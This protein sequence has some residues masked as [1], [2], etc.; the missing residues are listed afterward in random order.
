MVPKP[1]NSW[2]ERRYVPGSPRL[3]LNPVFNASSMGVPSITRRSYRA[4][5]PCP[6]TLSGNACN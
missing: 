6:Q 4:A 1:G 2:T 5:Q 3:A